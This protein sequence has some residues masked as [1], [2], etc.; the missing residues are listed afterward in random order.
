ML[1]RPFSQ[2][3]WTYA[4]DGRLL[5]RVPRLADVPEYEDSPKDI[6]KNIFDTQPISGK[7][8]AVPA[9]L[10]ALTQEVCESCGGDGKHECSCGN[11]HDCDNCDGSGQ[12]PTRAKGAQIGFHLVSYIYL[13]KIKDLPDIEICESAKDDIHALG[14]RFDS[15]GEGRLIPLRKE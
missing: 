15:G 2:A 9:D 11:I 7:W 1:M 3:G 10:P 8:Q 5:I 6:Q 13:H 4:T 12:V 14:I